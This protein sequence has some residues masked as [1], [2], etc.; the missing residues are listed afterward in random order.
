MAG[1]TNYFDMNNK[2][3]I[4]GLILCLAT[5]IIGCNDPVKEENAA[6]ATVNAVSPEISEGESYTVDPK[7]SVITWKGSMAIGSDSH[8]GYVYLSNGSLQI[9]EGR[10]SGGRAEIDLNTIGEKTHGSDNELVNHIKSPDFFDVTKYPVST[11][12][13]S[14]IESTNDGELFLTANLTI[15]EITKPV[16]FPAKMELKEGVLNATG[17]LVI[18]RTDWDIRYRSG[19]FYADLADKAITDS[20]EFD[21]KLVAKR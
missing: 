13:L 3:L 14:G 5:V 8:S 17:R 19:K 12:E 6:S 15:K 11:I 4:P 1:S 16:R 21:I 9:K 18:D 7:Q 2:Q 20:L 10:L